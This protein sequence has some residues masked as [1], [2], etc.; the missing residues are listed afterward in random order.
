MTDGTPEQHAS[1]V[2]SLEQVLVQ[3]ERAMVELGWTMVNVRPKETLA[4]LAERADTLE[5]ER[6][7]VVEALHDA[8]KILEGLSLASVQ[9]WM[10]RATEAR[11]EADR[12]REALGE[13]RFRLHTRRTGIHMDGTSQYPTPILAEIAAITESALAGPQTKEQT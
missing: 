1:A 6:D 5:R 13:I 4:A 2:R 9:G 7:A 10:D 12:L 3:Y 8:G 11:A